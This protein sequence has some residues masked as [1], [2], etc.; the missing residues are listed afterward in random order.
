MF[1]TKATNDEYIIVNKFLFEDWLVGVIISA[2]DTKSFIDKGSLQHLRTY[3]FTATFI[4]KRSWIKVG[5]LEA[6]T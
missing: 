3:L 2:D 5:S 4:G 1:R 6:N